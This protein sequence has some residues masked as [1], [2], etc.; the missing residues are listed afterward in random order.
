MK[1]RNPRR[2]IPPLCAA[3]ITATLLVVGIAVARS[4]VTP[5][6]LT[7]TLTRNVDPGQWSFLPSG[8]IR[9]RDRVSD[10]SDT[11]T[12]PR[13]TGTVRATMNCN[14]DSNWTGPCWGATHEQIGDG[15]WDGTWNGNLNLQTGSGDA[16]TVL[17]G[18]GAFD[19]LQMMEHCAYIYGVGTCAGRILDTNGQ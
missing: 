6:T 16:D 4:T 9:L 18:S 13:L 17:H 14:L 3:L 19:G 15:V 2:V 1:L 8:K 5:F 7:E 10:Y 12:D 11:A